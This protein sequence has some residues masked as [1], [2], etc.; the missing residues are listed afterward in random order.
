MIKNC[1]IDSMLADYCLD[2]KQNGVIDHY[3]NFDYSSKVEAY[4][5]YWTLIRS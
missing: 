5:K 4:N 1:K 2:H 3:L